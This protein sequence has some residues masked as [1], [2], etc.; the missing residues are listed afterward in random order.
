MQEDASKFLVE[1]ESYLT[2]STIEPDSPRAVAAFHLHLTGPALIWF[3]N[4]T[5]KD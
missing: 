4:L 2:L 5:I 1:F 3:N